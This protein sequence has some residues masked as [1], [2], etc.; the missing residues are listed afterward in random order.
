MVLHSLSR[1]APGLLAL[2]PKLTAD[3]LKPGRLLR[4]GSAAGHDVHAAVLCWCG[5]VAFAAPIAGWPHAPAVICGAFPAEAAESAVLL[6]DS[7]GASPDAVDA[8]AEEGGVSVID[9]FGAPLDSPP[10]SLRDGSRRRLPL[11]AVCPGQADLQPICASL[12][13]GTGATCLFALGR[14]SS[15]PCTRT[16]TTAGLAPTPPPP[17]AAGTAAIDV[18]TPVGRG[19][20]WRALSVRLLR[21]FSPAPPFAPPAHPATACRA[22]GPISYQLWLIAHASA[23]PSPCC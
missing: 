23:P 13:T 8:A 11:M 4:V 12:H 3:S 14:V 10:T 9:C 7:L 20:V 16:A 15:S 1:V 18:L 6:D 2:R 5:G 21:T 22:P 19:Q 17:S